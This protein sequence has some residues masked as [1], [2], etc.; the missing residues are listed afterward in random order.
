VVF[1]VFQNLRDGRSAIMTQM[2]TVSTKSADFESVRDDY[3][4]RIAR[5]EI[6][7]KSLT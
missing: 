5:L 1:M 2:V 3:S 6:H 4:T 7:Q